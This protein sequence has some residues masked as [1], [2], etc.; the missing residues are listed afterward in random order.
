MHQQFLSE[1]SAPLN[2]GPNGWR[3]SGARMRVRCHRGLGRSINGRSVVYYL[4]LLP[5]LGSSYTIPYA[6]RL[7][8]IPENLFP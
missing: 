3:L 4:L 2:L 1:G 8:L 6:V 5:V 7:S